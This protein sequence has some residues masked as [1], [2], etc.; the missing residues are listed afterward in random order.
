MFQLV[1]DYT[2]TMKE[3]DLNIT[4]NNDDVN[5]V[6]TQNIQN[7]TISTQCCIQPF[8][9]QRTV[10]MQVNIVPK[11]HVSNA[12]VQVNFDD[13][14]FE[15]DFRKEFLYSSTPLKKRKIEDIENDDKDI[16]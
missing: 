5:T 11:K 10:K 8:L 9:I 15:Q 16:E 12:A 13:T 7:R 2:D 14:E 1:E 4:P 6:I 3:D